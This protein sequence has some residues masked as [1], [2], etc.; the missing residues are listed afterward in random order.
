MLVISAVANSAFAPM[1]GPVIKMQW[2]KVV[3][4]TLDEIIKA[5]SEM[6]NRE[7]RFT[8]SMFMHVCRRMYARRERESCSAKAIDRH[9]LSK[10]ER[11]TDGER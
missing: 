9:G 11:E 5:M 8:L 1:R 7:T 3:L 4:P 10:Q 2:A 6:T